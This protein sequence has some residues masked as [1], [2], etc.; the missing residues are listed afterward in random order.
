MTQELE[1][2][3]IKEEVEDLDKSDID[4][5]AEESEFEL[6]PRRRHGLRDLTKAK[7]PLEDLDHEN[8]NAVDDFAVNDDEDWLPE[9]QDWKEEET[10]ASEEDDVAVAIKPWE[11]TK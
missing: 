10:M 8:N 5:G 2:V 6:G 11:I 9:A 3:S 1:P 7:D 4:K